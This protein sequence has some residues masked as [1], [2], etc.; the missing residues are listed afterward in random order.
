MR[1]NDLTRGLIS[2]VLLAISACSF[3]EPYPSKAVKV[4]IPYGTGTSVDAVTRIVVDGLSK[5]F[6]QP[7]VVDNRTGASGMIG[8]AFVAKAPADGYTVLGSPAS[9]TSVPALRKNVPFDP[10]L[11]FAG[12]T[13]FA[14][15]PLVLVVS[16]VRGLQSVQDLVAAAKAKQGSVTFASGGV[17]TATHLAAE[18]MRLAAGFDALHVP[19]KSSSEAMPGVLVGQIDF[20]YTSV[21]AALPLVKAGR[22]VALAMSSR[23]SSTLPQVPTIEEAGVP[24]S[25]FSSWSG[26]LVPS[27]TP[28]DIVQRLY[29]ETVKVIA[30]PEVKDR[31]LKIGAEPFTMKPEEFDSFIRRELSD[32][33]RMVKILGIKPE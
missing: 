30:T 12:V 19:F 16:R 28:R 25:L 33:E 26:M 10:A 23:R 32:N 5:S 7:F 13:P 4:V 24:N 14:D 3:A 21:A 29:E 9:H 6:G 17:G 8:A 1:P 15:S 22:L 18:K 11:D 20:T 31:L 2:L 27:K